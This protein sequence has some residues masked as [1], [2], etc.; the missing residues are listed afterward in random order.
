MEKPTPMV[1]SFYRRLLEGVAA[2]PGTESV[3]LLGRMR[4]V[5]FGVLGQPEAPAD[6]RPWAGFSEVS[7]SAFNTLRIPLKSGRYLSESD[8]GNA[9]WA[10]V[11]NETFARRFFRDQD[12]IGKRL[13][14]RC[15]SYHVDETQPR[16][17]VGVVGDVK[18]GLGNETPPA[19]YTSY[20]QQPAVF[21]GG[22]TTTHIDQEIVMRV[23]AVPKTF[24]SDL[25]K[26]VASVDPDQVVEAIMSMD[27]FLDRSVDDTRFVMR[28]L[29]IFA[30]LALLLAIVGIYGVMSYF[31]NQRTHEI[32][33]RMALGA[34]RRRVL[35]LVTGLGLKLTLIGVAAG[36]GLAVALARLISDFLFGVK[37]VDP[38]TFAAVAAMLMCVALAACGLPA[39][40]ASRVD[41]MV[42]LRE[43]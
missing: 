26:A 23:A 32:G 28:L 4:G 9:P 12:P 37:P 10:A 43:E 2:L 21:A 14:V 27:R 33:I 25:K 38:A 29:E 34:E 17:V 39:Y 22:C 1:V 19:I 18:F 5:T 8:S 30:G 15:E 20:L 11:I 16:T 7:S 3:G 36:T 42:A 13:L 31:V 35:R 40:R 24:A 41:P 6:K